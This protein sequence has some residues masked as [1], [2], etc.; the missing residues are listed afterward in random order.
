MSN[1]APVTTEDTAGAPAP[2]TPGSLVA[3]AT[4]GYW[5]IVASAL[6]GV[7][8]FGASFIAAVDATAAKLLLALTK[9]DVGLGNVDNTSD[10]NKPVSTAQAA[11]D[12]LRVLKA[13]DT[14]TGGLVISAGGL[15][16]N[17]LT[18]G[19]VTF[20]GT[21][22]RL[23]DDSRLLWDNVAKYLSIG[24]TYKF[25]VLGDQ[26]ANGDLPANHAL[27]G[28]TLGSLAFFAATT[29]GGAAYKVICGY[30]NGSTIKSA[31]EVNNTTGSALGHLQ[32]MKNGGYVSIGGG[33]QLSKVVVYTPTLTP[34]AVDASDGYVEQT[35][36]VTGL[37]TTDTI[38]VNQPAMTAPPHCQLVAFRVSA[39]DTLALTFRTV[40]GSHLPPAGVYRIAAFRS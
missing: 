7:S 40:S 11:A 5:D 9:S 28:S 37:A 22:G 15:T 4:P 32:L 13:G 29:T 19:R 14:M 34:A 25:V 12:N 38:T 30:Y 33:T 23:V 18:A 24:S 17:T 20:A 16:D 8:A 31:W 3:S 2:L 6:S 39:A 36:T 1:R 26:P 21:S 35:F 27:M 10:V